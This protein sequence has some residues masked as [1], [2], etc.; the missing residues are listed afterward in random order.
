M[1][2]EF[3]V[4]RWMGVEG[5][6]S[7]SVCSTLSVYREVLGVCLVSEDEIATKSA[8]LA[9]TGVITDNCCEHRKEDT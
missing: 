5:N 4:G 7:A 1:R 8:L 9:L 6:S 3:D 2:S